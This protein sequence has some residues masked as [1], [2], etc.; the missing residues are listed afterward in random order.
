MITERNNVVGSLLTWRVQIFIKHA[1]LNIL[2]IWCSSEQVCAFKG[3]PV[4]SLK[5]QG[6]ENAPA[7]P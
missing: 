2:R 4:T 6:L 5:Q 7:L 1:I 3:R